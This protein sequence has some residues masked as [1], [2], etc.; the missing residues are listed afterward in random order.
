MVV[1]P[2]KKIPDPV[3]INNA[4]RINLT[5]YSDRLLTTVKDITGLVIDVWVKDP[6]A[7][8][9]WTKYTATHVSEAGG[10]AF[11][12]LTAATHQTVGNDVEL[13]VEVDN[14]L[15]YPR[16]SFDFIEEAV[17]P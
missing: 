16:Y 17:A 9:S 14:E 1:T 5:I 7:G 12:T 15:A 13:R 6:L 3:P 2:T 11:I 8:T 10:T 4:A